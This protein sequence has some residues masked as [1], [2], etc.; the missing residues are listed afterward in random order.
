MLSFYFCVL[1]LGLFR[2]VR[3]AWLSSD[4]RNA[5]GSETEPKRLHQIQSSKIQR[6]P[7]E[8]SELTRVF[9]GGVVPGSMTL[10][11]GDPGIGKSSLVLQLAKM[12]SAIRVPSFSSS[13]AGASASGIGAAVGVG[14]RMKPVLYISGEETGGQLKM[15]A[16][17]LGIMRGGS[18]T[19]LLSY[20][21]S[22][23]RK[24]MP[25]TSPS[26]SSSV[27]SSA[28][29]SLDKPNANSDELSADATDSDSNSND[30]IDD[31]A[32]DN[33]FFWNETNIETIVDRLDMLRPSVVIVDSIQTMYT[34]ASSSA[35]GSVS[36]V[37]ECATKLLRV[38]KSKGI[39]VFLVGHVTK[40]GT[41]LKL[42][43]S[44]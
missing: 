26:A 35:I 24:T 3:S 7:L 1:R 8:S 12:L 13:S 16:N 41:A 44:I 37:K 15:R 25:A 4:D 32:E 5:A 36:Q 30:T 42:V 21:T 2:I 19:S 9:G 14:G 28:S 23:K 17:R 10:I 40:Q 34:E 43:Q 6:L 11:G 27:S 22:R 39:A 31:Q 29:A 18:H 20:T 33:L 38:A